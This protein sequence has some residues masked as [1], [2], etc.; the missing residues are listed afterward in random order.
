M[1]K[2]VH[3]HSGFVIALT[4]WAGDDIEEEILTRMTNI[5]R[6]RGNSVIMIVGSGEPSEVQSKLPK[7]NEK[8]AY[9]ARLLKHVEIL[10]SCVNGNILYCFHFQRIDLYSFCPGQKGP[11]LINMMFKNSTK[12]L[13]N[14]LKHPCPSPFHK[15]RIK[16]IVHG[17]PPGIHL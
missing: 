4:T 7:L 6:E 2:F 16:M 14:Q 12:L 1:S 5:L 13:F 15:R 10:M 11:N 9:F 8:V 17:I 3:S